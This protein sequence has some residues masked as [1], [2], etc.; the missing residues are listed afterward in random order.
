MLDVEVN[1]HQAFRMEQD[2]STLAEKIG[3]TDGAGEEPFVCQY[4]CPPP[5]T[6]PAPVVGPT[7]PPVDTPY[8]AWEVE[9]TNVD[10]FEDVLQLC[11]GIC[12]TPCGDDPTQKCF[13]SGVLGM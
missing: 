2:P 5:A 13:T 8:S 12:K 4:E 7:P 11:S 1:G 6:T 10:P 9:M 3:S